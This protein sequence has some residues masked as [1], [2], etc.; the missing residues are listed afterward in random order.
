MFLNFIALDGKVLNLNSVSI[1][2]QS[3]NGD[4]VVTTN[5][6]IELTFEGDDAAALFT[7][8][9]LICQVNDA[10]IAQAAAA[11]QGA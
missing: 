1:I 6:G 2:E 9:D 8:M 11:S 5:D 7:R 4:A 3:D 10:A